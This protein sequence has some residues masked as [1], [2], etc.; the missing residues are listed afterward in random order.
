MI[1]PPPPLHVT[2]VDEYKDQHVLNMSSTS[3]KN[4]HIHVEFELCLITVQTGGVPV[5]EFSV[6]CSTKVP[7]GAFDQCRHSIKPRHAY[8]R[9]VVL[10]MRTEPRV[11]IRR[12]IKD[13]PF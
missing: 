1:E 11:I 10:D 5:P 6:F 2:S 4:N 8:W 12:L 9:K 13:L 3:V 7:R